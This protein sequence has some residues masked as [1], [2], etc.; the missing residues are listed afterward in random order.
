MF[1]QIL[2][3]MFHTTKEV[4]VPNQPK[5]T[6]ADRK[7][8]TERPHPAGKLQF[9]L[10]KSIQYIRS[11]EQTF[12]SDMQTPGPKKY[13]TFYSSCSFKAKKNRWKFSFLMQKSGQ[14]YCF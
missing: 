5:A 11:Y 9:G 1:I 13:A 2:V 14:D 8:E 7:M 4:G 3:E 6:N 10:E 12:R